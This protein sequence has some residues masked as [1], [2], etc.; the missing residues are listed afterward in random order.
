MY[1]RMYACMRVCKYAG[2]HTHKSWEYRVVSFVWKCICVFYMLVRIVVSILV[3]YIYIYI[4][5]YAYCI[6]TYIHRHTYVHTCRNIYT[7]TYTYIHT[8]IHTFPHTNINIH[9]HKHTHTHTHKVNTCSLIPAWSTYVWSP[10]GSSRMVKVL[11]FAVSRSITD[12][13][14]LPLAD[15]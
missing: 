6:H 11:L 14:R 12:C 7:H 1:V 15:R 2:A 4:Y 10:R 8:C 9:K 13:K 3:L 5:I